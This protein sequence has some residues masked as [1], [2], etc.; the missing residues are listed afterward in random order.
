MVDIYLTPYFIYT[1]KD[2]PLI[3]PNPTHLHLYT[4]LRFDINFQ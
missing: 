4:L 1:G 3:R 2:R